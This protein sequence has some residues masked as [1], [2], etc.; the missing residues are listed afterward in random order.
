MPLKNRADTLRLRFVKSGNRDIP[1]GESAPVLN[2]AR[3]ACSWCVDCARGDCPRYFV[4]RLC[5]DVYSAL[6][7]LRARDVCVQGGKVADR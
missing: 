6:T 1:G 5:Y 2:P 4:T 3:L 7:M